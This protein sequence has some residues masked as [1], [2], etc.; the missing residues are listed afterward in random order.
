MHYQYDYAVIG[1]DMRQVYLTEELAGYANRIC[2]FALTRTPDERCFSE[3]SV[4]TAASSLEDACSLSACIIGPIPL[5]RNDSSLNQNVFHDHISIDRIF[6]GLKSS[7]SFFGGCI[8]E[9]RK[10][11][12]LKK[13]VRVFDLMTDPSLSYFNTIATAEGAVCEAIRQSPRNLRHS[14]CAILGY[15][16]CGFTLCQYLKGMSCRTYV[17]A[18]REEIRAQSSLISDRTG[19]IEDFISCAGEFDF[20][21]NTIPSEIITYEI[22]AR[23]KSTVTIIDIASAP[24]GVD[25]KA[26]QE[27]GLTAVLC[28]GLPGKYAPA[29]SAG[30]VRATIERILKEW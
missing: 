6:S 2:H 7:Q 10:T 24:G 17:A 13:G 8:P 23:L 3:S 9:E 11:A 18:R 16:K 15:G 14:S 1:G 19:T 29:S 12:A 28:P 22:L 25:F 26:A 20:I 5:C 30:A 21:F 27:L 4:V